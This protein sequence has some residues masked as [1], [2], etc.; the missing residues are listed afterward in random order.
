MK[1][2]KNKNY[3]EDTKELELLNKYYNVDTK[4]KNVTMPLHY[5]K[6]SDLIDNRVISKDNYLFDYDELTSINNRIKRIPFIYS[7]DIDIQID[8]YEDYDPKKMIDGFNDALE[9][10]SFNYGRER[11]KKWMQAAIVLTVGLII[12]FITAYGKINSWFG[13]G[14]RGEV[15][16]ETLDIFGW[17]FIW[18]CVTIAFLTPSEL[19]VN[20]MLF[21]LRVKKIA[22]LDI[23]NEVV[24]SEETKKIY[25]NWE[26]DKKMSIATRWAL[27][28]SGFSLIILGIIRTL[29]F[30][31]DF[32]ILNIES[33][34]LA[35][36]NVETAVL[37][38]ISFI[39]YTVQ[40]IVLFFAG[41]FNLSLY[42]RKNIHKKA[43][44]V[45]AVLLFLVL[46]L[47]II[48]LIYGSSTVSITNEVVTISMIL[49][50]VFGAITALYEME[51]EKKNK[52]VE[53][54]EEVSL[55][56]NNNDSNITNDD[57]AKIEVSIDEK[58]DND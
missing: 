34:K 55:D 1:I 33:Y 14:R 38:V 44:I 26:N 17:V 27:L 6:A 46:I 37:F 58:R 8:D 21:K 19:G 24:Y 25:G 28:I 53:N 48:G 3:Y 13:S 30:I 43:S 51:N 29:E 36:S 11:R 18:Q 5:D 15:F 39:Y 9:L 23:N 52:N 16:A 7:V 41:L 22:F 40:L 56:E 49:M 35:F 31:G 4:N 32:N 45:F 54:I 50:Y 2:D 20:S 47:D 10:N 12:L 57:E 42:K